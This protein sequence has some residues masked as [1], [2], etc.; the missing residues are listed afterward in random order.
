MNIYHKSLWAGCL[1][2]AAA[3]FTACS[4]D[5]SPAAPAADGAEVW[6][7]FTIARNACDD[8]ASRTAFTPDG[9]G[10][11]ATWT[12]GDRIVVTN[13]AG[14]YAGT[15]DLVRT[16]DDR[17][18]G[19][20]E[21]TL[22]GLTDGSAS[23]V[24]HYLGTNHKADV[25]PGA[26]YTVTA[27]ADGTLASQPA[28]DMMYAE[29]TVDIAG[30]QVAPE[31]TVDMTR[32]ISFGYFRTLARHDAATV[33]VSGSGASS[34]LTYTLATRSVA[35]TAGAGAYTVTLGEDGSF[36][37]P[38]IPGEERTL[39]ITITGSDNKTYAYTFPAAT[40][41]AGKY[42]N[43]AA[44]GATAPAPIEFTPEEKKYDYPGY[45]N[46]DPRN[47]LHKFAKYNLTREADGSVI[48]TFV[49][50]ET[51]N[52]ALYQWGRNYGY[53]DTYGVFEG[54]Y[55]VDNGDNEF[56]NFIDAIGGLYP[57]ENENNKYYLDYYIYNPQNTSFLTGLVYFTSSWNYLIYPHVTPLY[58]TTSETIV[59][60]PTKCFMDGSGLTGDYWT[61]GDGGSNWTERATKCGYKDANPCPKEQGKWRLPK[62]AD[63]EEILPQKGNFEG[64]NG[65]SLTNIINTSIPAEYRETKAGIP[66]VIQW[67]YNGSYL[68]IKAKVVEKNFS[69]ISSINWTGDDIVTRIFPA[70]GQIRLS[71]NEPTSGYYKI[72]RPTHFG[73]D[74]IGYDSGYWFISAGGNCN[75][76]IGSYWSEDGTAF[77]FQ[78]Y[79][80]ISNK[81]KQAFIGLSTNSDK[82]NAYAIR[83][84]MDIK[85]EQQ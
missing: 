2:V 84:V 19:T 71:V 73:V 47:P 75:D 11:Q 20:F 18:T 10:L 48:N 58:Y 72:A 8:P 85:E 63:W 16:S 3:G 57:K 55:Y 52:G 12:D 38:V 9:T 43:A 59:N 76:L 41:P 26:A 49:A 1:A 45:E 80:R 5:L 4:D 79:M 15:L 68:T 44:D 34:S 32:A 77:H 46:E 7:S 61:F 42:L 82:E 56:N 39:T 35:A 40:V 66:Y 30:G 24:L 21:G 23:I 81:Q 17:R 64:N 62:K 36:H 37:I 69:N 27:P 31:Q 70:T 65:Q 83:P 25:N 29:L 6:A 74:D 60:N 51:E 67:Q 13:A 50:S 33:T 54:D 53:E 14:T 22:S 28:A 78:N